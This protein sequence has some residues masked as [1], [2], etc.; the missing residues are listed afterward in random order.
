[1]PTQDPGVGRAAL[2]QCVELQRGYEACAEKHLTARQRQ[3]LPPP[4]SYT[5]QVGKS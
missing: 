5:Q 1:M 4:A 3:L 2:V